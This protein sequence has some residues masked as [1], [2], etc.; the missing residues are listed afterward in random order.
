MNNYANNTSYDD[1]PPPPPPLASSPTDEILS[2]AEDDSDSVQD[3]SISMPVPQQRNNARR[4]EYVNMPVSQKQQQQQR[5]QQQQYRNEEWHEPKVEQPGSKKIESHEEFSRKNENRLVPGGSSVASSSPDPSRSAPPPLPPLRPHNY[6]NMAG[7]SY[8]P[9]PN[10]E[11]AGR[12]FQLGSRNSRYTDSSADESL[13]LGHQSN[14]QNYNDMMTLRLDA[15]LNYH[16][17]EE[18]QNDGYSLKPEQNNTVQH[19]QQQQPHSLQNGHQSKPVIQQNYHRRNGHDHI[20]GLRE[21]LQQPQQQQQQHRQISIDYFSNDEPTSTSNG[22]NNHQ[23][24][25]DFEQNGDIQRAQR[26]PTGHQR[27]DRASLRAKHKQ[28]MEDQKIQKMQKMSQIS[29]R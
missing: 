6:A 21:T 24:G 11:Q 28:D 23:N 25:G 20:N 26:V 8:L 10:P 2:R 19:Q 1:L 5:Q 17:E 18:K 15:R 4:N 13:S 3:S 14:N 22:V 9:E 16:P 27:R 12:H 7:F 29:T